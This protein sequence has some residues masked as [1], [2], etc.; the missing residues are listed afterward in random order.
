MVPLR[1]PN[2]SQNQYVDYSDYATLGGSAGKKGK[3][4]QDG[5]TIYMFAKSRSRKQMADRCC[6]C[7]LLAE[8][9]RAFNGECF[10]FADLL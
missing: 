1:L 9:P 5:Q 10:A 8:L 3:G 6:L 4:K 2:S 7:L